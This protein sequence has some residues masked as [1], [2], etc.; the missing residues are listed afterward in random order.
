MLKPSFISI[1]LILNCECHA[2]LT[3]PGL[4][5][6]TI[7]S[8][9]IHDKTLEKTGLSINEDDITP[10]QEMNPIKLTDAQLHEANVWGLTHEEEIRYIELMQN[11][12][13]L[14]YE[15]L[16]Q[17][18]IDVLGINARNKEERNHFAELAA[19]QEA[20][21]VAKNIAWNNAFYKAYN[22]LFQNV[23]IIGHFDPTPYAPTHYK[24][25]Q[26]QENDQ[27]FLFIKSTDAVKTVLM[28]LH[29]LI[30]LTP[31]A[32]LNIMLL[33]SDDAGIQHWA[34]LHQI[35]HNLVPQHISIEQG[36]IAFNALTLKKKKTPLLLLARNNTSHI[37]DLGRF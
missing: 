29:E 15:S 30:T 11:K 27:L 12:S 21:K 9:L 16:H 10:D 5:T 2:N 19:R 3:I 18:P 24:P 6:Q 1:L 32:H 13:A 20:Q 4:A 23:P 22:R 17:T 14:Y 33:N 36:D 35:P 8:Q 28:T 31:T 26:L 25:M 37:V 7:N 34:N